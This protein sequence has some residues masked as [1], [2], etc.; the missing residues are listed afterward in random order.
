M[1][2]VHFKKFIIPIV[3]TDRKPLIGYFQI[4]K[5]LKQKLMSKLMIIHLNFLFIML[6]L[7]NFQK[8]HLNNTQP[9]INVKVEAKT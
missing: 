8:F 4:L 6:Y 1:P 5:G 3:S 2:V 9:K 7:A